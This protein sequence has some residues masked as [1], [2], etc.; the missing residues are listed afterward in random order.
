MSKPWHSPAKPLF[1]PLITS[2]RLSTGRSCRLVLKPA[3][4]FR[5]DSRKRKS[6][7]PV[8]VRDRLLDCGNKR[9]DEVLLIVSPRPLGEGPGERDCRTR[10]PPP[11]PSPSGGGSQQ[12]K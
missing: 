11:Q 8:E 7:R 9:I 12:P 10:R 5:I 6:W 3:R 4:P 1:K 2:E